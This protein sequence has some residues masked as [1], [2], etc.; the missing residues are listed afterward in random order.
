MHMSLH[1]LKPQRKNEI[2]DCSERLHS[3]R[4]AFRRGTLGPTDQWDNPKR[5]EN[6]K[7]SCFALPNRITKLKCVNSEVR[8]VIIHPEKGCSMAPC[9]SHHGNHTRQELDHYNDPSGTESCN[10]HTSLDHSTCLQV[11]IHGQWMLPSLMHSF[12]GQSSIREL[13]PPAL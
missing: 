2:S 5:L 1:S 9:R 6:G 7:A 10:V 8:R 12:V 11:H 4:Q 3:D 13:C